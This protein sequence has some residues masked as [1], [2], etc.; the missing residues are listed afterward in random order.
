[1]RRGF[2]FLGVVSA[3]SAA[4]VGWVHHSQTLERHTMRQAV[5]QDIAKLDKLGK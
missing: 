4:T 3:A 2:V 1:M 5:L